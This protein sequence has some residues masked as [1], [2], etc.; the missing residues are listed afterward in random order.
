MLQQVPWKTW[1]VDSLIIS[2]GLRPIFASRP[3]LWK[4]RQSTICAG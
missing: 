3:A 4:H 2:R 1:G